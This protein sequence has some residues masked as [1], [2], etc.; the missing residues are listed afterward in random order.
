MYECELILK[1]VARKEVKQVV[2]RSRKGLSIFKGRGR[3]V[4]GDE[5]P[6]KIQEC[7][8]ETDHAGLCGQGQE[9]GL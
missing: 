2:S 1:D 5:W 6:R 3:G 8:Q 7:G 9:F 4:I